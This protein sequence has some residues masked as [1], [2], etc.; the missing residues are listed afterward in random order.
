MKPSVVHGSKRVPVDKTQIKG[1]ELDMSP[2]AKALLVSKLRMD[3]SIAFA[4]VC[5][6]MLP[7]KV[8]RQ[9]KGMA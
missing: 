2:L 6:G 5:S 1:T 4:P 9:L 7:E 3:D 8:H